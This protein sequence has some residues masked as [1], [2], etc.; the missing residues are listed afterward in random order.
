MPIM[1]TPAIATRGWVAIDAQFT[2]VLQ[3]STRRPPS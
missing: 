1:T 3:R 2:A